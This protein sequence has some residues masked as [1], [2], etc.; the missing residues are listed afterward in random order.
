MNLHLIHV[1]T[2]FFDNQLM[3]INPSKLN[4]LNSLQ[5]LRLHNN[6]ITKIE[7]GIFTFRQ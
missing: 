2:S 4:E 1:S 5:Y 7:E 6:R 3:T